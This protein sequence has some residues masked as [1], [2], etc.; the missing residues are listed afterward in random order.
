M[1]SGNLSTE[2]LSLQDQLKSLTG[3]FDDAIQKDIQLGQLKEM[4]Q[5]IKILRIKLEE[6]IY[7][8]NTSQKYQ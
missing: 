3:A 5:Q 8:C 7:K 4:L 1:P 6:L 2:I